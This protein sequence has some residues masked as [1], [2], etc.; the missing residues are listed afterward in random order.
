MLVV[1]DVPVNVKVEQAMLK[2][3]G[4]ADV[5]TALSGAE[6]LRLL[7]ERAFDLVLTDLWMPEMDGYALCGRIREDASL[8][9]LPVYAVTAD[10]EA[11]KT[12]EG[13]GFDGLLLKPLTMDKLAAFL[14]GI[15]PSAA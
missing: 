7:G 9:R 14:A 15:R 3:A 10:V 4:V 13:K 12:M 1:D 8:A 2:R 11:G 6:A 5:A